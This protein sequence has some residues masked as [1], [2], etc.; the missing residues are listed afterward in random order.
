MPAEELATFR[1]EDGLRVELVAAEPLVFAP[2]AMR[3]DGDGRLWVAEMRGYM[4][5][6]DGTGE[7]APVG[8]IAVL[9]DSDGDGR[10]DQR[11]VFLDGLVLPRAVL[12]TRGGALVIAPPELFFAR[13]TD[14]DGVADER[15]TVA[16]GLGGL[17]SPEHAINGLL[18]SLDNW[19]RVANADRR[20]RYG[21]AGWIEGRTAGG[22]Q[23]G[24]AQD[25]EGR[26]FYDTNSQSLFAD[27]VPSHYTVRNPNLGR[28]AGVLHRVVHD[29]TVRPAHATPGVNRGYRD[30]MLREDGSL[31]TF[32]AACA[33]FIHRGDAL[34]E[35]RGDAFVC[36]PAGNLIKR[37]ELAERSDGRLV[38]VDPRTQGEFLTST[39][40]RFRPVALAGGPDGA[41][42]V[43]D[44]YRGVIQHRLFVTSFLRAQIE[45]RELELPLACGRIWRITDRNEVPESR[46]LSDASW[47]EVLERLG[48]PNGWWRD[49]AQR[50]IVEEGVGDRELIERVAALVEREANPLCRLHALW[51]LEGLGAATLPRFEGA[52]RDPDPR[53]RRAALRVAEGSL[54]QDARYTV[55]RML[56]AVPGDEPRTLWQAAHSVGEAG[57]DDARAALLGIVNASGAELTDPILRG[58]VLSGLNGVELEFL[59]DLFALPSWS[60]ETAGR[61]SLLSEVAR[62][63]GHDGRAERIDRALQAA[64]ALDRARRWQLAAVLRGLLDARPPGPDGAPAPLSISSS[65]GALA[66]IAAAADEATGALAAELY[67]SLLWPGRKDL[68]LPVVRE[69]DAVERARFDRGRAIYSLM[70]ARCHMDTGRGERGKAPPLRA[71]SW[72]LGDEARLARIVRFGLVGPIDVLDQRWNGEMPAWAGSDEELA[73]LLTYLRREWGNGVEPVTPESVRRALQAAGPR[74]APFTAEELDAEEL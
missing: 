62:C 42:Y 2:V 3:F 56:A 69:L 40:E 45:E 58:A 6:V 37:F 68:E 1:V 65:G 74:A 49:V 26:I 20:W 33:P 66:M 23:W 22:G 64:S 46:P 48:H 30:G 57:R 70:C 27:L 36:E 60:E 47:T 14:G 41:L 39:D 5:D 67:D 54:V 15:E 35:L 11:D 38:G 52:L 73:D 24:I 31:T 13:D 29:E 32:T 28:A 10:M 34:D 18:P 50:T 55:A 12:P 53:V 8:S 25:D 17:E 9:S 19:I 7:D 4:P 51:T 21:H 43:A 63:V 72:V 44:M 61:A 16:T 59:E 71:S